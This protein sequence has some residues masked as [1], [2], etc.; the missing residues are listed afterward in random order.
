M[1]GDFIHYVQ[2]NLCV[3]QAKIREELK[4]DKNTP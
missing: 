3:T 4:L 2:H 1:K